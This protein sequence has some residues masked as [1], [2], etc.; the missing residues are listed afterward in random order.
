MAKV[1][2]SILPVNCVL[3]AEVRRFI[4]PEGVPHMVTRSMSKLA[5]A[6]GGLALAALAGAGIASADGLSRAGNQHHLQLRPGYA[7]LQAQIPGDA[8]NCSSSGRANFFWISYLVSRFAAARPLANQ[9]QATHP[10]QAQ[11]IIPVI[12]QV[13]A[14]CNNF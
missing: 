4:N 1:D 6:A 11:R 2:H 14:T 3:D 9:A 10:A 13:V 5:A 12:N 8:T 7:A